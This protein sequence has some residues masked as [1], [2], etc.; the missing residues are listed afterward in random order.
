[1]STSRCPLA[2]ALSSSSGMLHVG[3]QSIHPLLHTFTVFSLSTSDARESG[4]PSHAQQSSEHPRVQE[5]EPSCPVRPHVGSK[6]LSPIHKSASR[7]HKSTAGNK[8]ESDTECIFLRHSSC[9]PCPPL[10][11]RMLASVPTF[12][13]HCSRSYCR[14]FRTPSLMMLFSF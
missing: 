2:A 13:K 6:G 12:A 5:R 14:H 1:M 7:L 3:V 8:N 9:A 11:L 4:R 10:P